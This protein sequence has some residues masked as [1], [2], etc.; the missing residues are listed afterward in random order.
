M[1]KRTLREIEQM[2]EGS[3]TCKKD[4]NI[5]IHGVSIDSRSIKSGELFIPIKGEKFDGH[6]F[7]LDAIESGAVATLW[8]KTEPIPPNANIP[9]ILVEDTLVAIQNLAKSYSKQLGMKIIGITGSNGKTSTKDLLAGILSTKYKTGKTIGNLNNHLGVPLTI[10][11]FEEDTEIGIIEMGIS[12]L[13]EADLLS[14]IAE[15]DVAIITNIGEAHLETLYTRENIAKGKLEIINHLNKDGLFIYPGDEPLIKNEIKKLNPEFKIETFG[16]D[17]SNTYCPK[18]ISIGENGLSFKLNESSP[19]VINL[20]LLGKHQVYNAT[21]AIA[22]AKYFNISFEDIQIGLKNADITRMRSD[23]IHTETCTILDDSYKSNP[24]SVLAALD[25]LYSLDKY[26]RKIVVLGDMLGLGDEEISMHR[27]IGE[28]ID[29]SQID[30][31]FTIGPLAEHIAKGASP[32]IPKNNIKSC[33]DKEEL[34]NDLKK[35]VTKDSIVLIKASRD[36]HLENVVDA[37]KSKDSSSK[38]I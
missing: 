15:P 10:L 37:L 3:K 32:M 36:L 9:F 14:S 22:A 8:N 11:G 6:N 5:V 23:L 1:I 19:N 28:K 24:A 26:N 35:I 17:P 25:T 12:E 16:Q 27:E 21:A 2:I 33:V 31:L 29:P 38:A 30:Y 18:L 20:D 13:G 7:I 4:R 34:I